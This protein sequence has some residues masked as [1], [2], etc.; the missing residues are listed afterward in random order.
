MVRPAPP[1][2]RRNGRTPSLPLRKRQYEYARGGKPLSRS[3]TEPYFAA[4]ALRRP[5]AMSLPD[6]PGVTA[7]E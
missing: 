5:A 7:S 1:V 2:Q 3:P 4:N 6:M